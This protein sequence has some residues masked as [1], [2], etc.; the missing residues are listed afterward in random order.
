MPVRNIAVD[1][2]GFP[3][4]AIWSA[5]SETMQFICIE[6][7]YSTAD[8]IDSN[9]RLEDKPNLK[10]APGAEWTTALKFTINFE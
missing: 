9:G 2:E 3:Y 7:W 6:P 1:I 10:L 5:R 8:P 4:V